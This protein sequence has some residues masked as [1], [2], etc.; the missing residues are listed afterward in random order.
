MFHIKLFT[1][2]CLNFEL[3]PANAPR[4]LLL[5]DVAFHG[6]GTSSPGAHWKDVLREV[7][8][9]EEYFNIFK[10]HYDLWS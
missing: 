4:Y 6:A 2:T 10:I 7:N 3:S 9:S 5:S 8:L 1:S